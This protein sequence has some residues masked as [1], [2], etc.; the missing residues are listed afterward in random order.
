MSKHKDHREIGRE[1]DL[2]SFHE[3]APGAPFWHHK[4]MIIFKELEKFIRELQGQND[5]QEISTP[6][7]VK[8]EL[9]KKSGHLENYKENMFQV[10][11][12]EE[13]A[14]PQAFYLKPMN[15]PESALVYQTKIRSWR[16]LPLRLA[17]L[18]RLHRNELSGV[19]GGLFRVRQ[20]TMDDAHIYCRQDQIKSE[21]IKI[22]KM[23][24][25]FYKKLG[26]PVS[27]GLATRPEK[28]MGDKKLWDE[29]E[30]IIEEA[31][32]EA[33]L[34]YKIL[35]GEGAF[36]GPKVHF[37]IKDS[38][39][40]TWTLATAQLD[41]QIPERLELEYIDKSGKPQR[42]AIIHRAIFGTFERFIGVLTEHFQGAFP[43]WL[44]PVQTVLI[45]VSEKQQKFSEKILKELKE[46]GIRA[47]LY[48][49]GETLPKRVREAELQKIPYILVVGEK[50][51]KNGTANVRHKGKEEEI[52]IENLIA[53]MTK[54]IKDKAL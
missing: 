30:K 16:D 31:L 9:F 28:A 22:L 7:M 19:L 14:A 3:V 21:F 4:G 12:G 24:E 50:E 44:A 47:E 23:T 52:K 41:F 32:K 43:L 1:L 42:P 40:R 46:N 26:L 37:D 2:F 39:D 20:F 33:G 49:S 27:Y 15:C 13:G 17:E 48:E 10:I 5:Y 29:A 51:E 45:P 53:K 11:V 18:G 38:L 25:E 36:Y 54:E 6:I 35:E 8:E 34:K